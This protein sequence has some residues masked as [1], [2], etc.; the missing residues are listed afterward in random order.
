MEKM[1]LVYPAHGHQAHKI[2]AECF[3]QLTHEVTGNLIELKTDEEV[4][5]KSLSRYSKVVIL[6][7]DAENHLTGELYLD[8]E[9]KDVCFRYG[10]DEYV[11]KSLCVNGCKV[12]LLT[13]GRPRAVLYA[14]YRYFERFC[15]CRWF[16]D[17]DR[18]GTCSELP[19]EGIMLKE[20]PRFEYRGIRYF[21][22]RSLHRFQAEHWSLEDWKREIH[23][24]LK[25]RLNLFMLRIGFDDLFQKAF[26]NE[27]HYPERDGQL[28]EATD[29]FNDR[30][31]FW[32]LEYRGELRKQILQYAFSCDLMHVEDCGTMTH[33]YTRTPKEFLDT[34]K[35]SLLRGQKTA[36]Y[37]EDT[38]LI[39][40]IRKDE[41]MNHY[42][43]LTETH[44]REY[45]K[46]EVFHTI[47]LA[48][49][50][51]SDDREENLR[52]KLYTY[53]RIS[54][55][56]KETYPNAPLMIA[57]W[58]LWQYYT[59][60]EIQQLV[61]E[62]DPEQAIILDYTS[63]TTNENNFT[64]WG[65]IGKFPWVFGVFSAYEANSEL[66]GNYDMINERLAIA[67]K[68]P[69][70]KGVILWP[71][72]SHGD[73]FCGEY[74]AFYA[75]ESEEP[76]TEGMI[77]KYC[78]DRYDKAIGERMIRLWT[79]LMPIIR[80]NVWDNRFS[81]MFRD[82]KRLALFADDAPE[83]YGQWLKQAVELQSDAMKILTE[84]TGV[85]AASEQDELLRRDIFD[86]AR[87]VVS[88]YLVLGLMEC[89][90]RYAKKN[91]IEKLEK[92][93]GD[94]LAL[95][96]GFAELLSLHEDYSMYE[97]LN[98]LEAVTETNPNFEVTLKHN[99]D[100]YYCRSF[101]FELAEYLYVPEAKILFEEVT[102]AAAMG[103]EINRDRMSERMSENTK[104]F[105]ET[106]LKE[107]NDIPRR[108]LKA[109][110]DN[111]IEIIGQMQFEG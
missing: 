65:V 102:R 59:I 58:D 49:R 30:N 25:K 17:G 15:H 42:F 74:T 34:V 14:V 3:A 75:W 53:H 100:N 87:T 66:M 81:S 22:H 52:L 28:P 46:P 80:L 88:R 73:T 91:D 107:M 18:I 29:G 82:V 62:L 35:P 16:W 27:V 37:S 39:W 104:K 2:A 38:G 105:Y 11:I 19:L 72:L 1:I 84:L 111:C 23:W 89:Q 7:N 44:I 106:S 61:A 90:V 77:E 97:S 71:E 4:E 33:W 93:M 47:G 60:E 68:D 56:L 51:F 64:N 6:G 69:M 36:K 20:S 92:A 55:Y 40:D 8:G 70:C 98:R 76:S 95:F 5:R 10:T 12:L 63:D 101:I 57:S 96:V 45:G 94:T 43:K 79:K 109:V 110:I 108:E 85:I 86:V 67:Q 41:N 48:E 50:M 13:G 32:S 99:A 54:A 9:L 26:P 83:K 103:V 21:A 24:M 78:R 31:L